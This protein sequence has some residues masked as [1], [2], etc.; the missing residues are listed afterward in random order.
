M[1]C[2]ILKNIISLLSTQFIFLGLLLYRRDWPVHKTK[3]RGIPLIQ[4]SL[5]LS[6]ITH[7]FSKKQNKSLS[8]KFKD[9]DKSIFL[10]EMEC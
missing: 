8:D 3:K 9:R 2:K 7:S 10:L 4:S 6:S 1:N 5:S